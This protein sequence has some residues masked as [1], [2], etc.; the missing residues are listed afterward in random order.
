MIRTGNS[1][2]F[3]TS[4]SRLFTVLAVLLTIGGSLAATSAPAGAAPGNLADIDVADVD[5]QYVVAALTAGGTIQVEMVACGSTCTKS[6]WSSLGGGFKSVNVEYLAQGRPVVIARRANG[7][8]WY[9][10]GSCSATNCTWINWKDLGG[11]VIDLATSGYAGNCV[12]LAGQSSTKR[13]YQA[14]VCTSTAQGW[15]YAGGPLDQIAAHSDLIFGTS[16]SHQMWWFKNGTWKWAGG[17]VTQPAAKFGDTE[18][19]GIAQSSRRLWCVNTS[20]N[21]WTNHGGY[22]RKLDD[23]HTIGIGLAWDA[24]VLDGEENPGNYGEE[25]IA[26]SFGGKVNEVAWTESKDFMV[27]IGSDYRPWYQGTLGTGHGTWRAL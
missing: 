3:R 10:R 13:V 6:G 24:W 1:H 14:R 22:W 4:R 19:C 23:D 18:L 26:T 2:P 20:T 5:G 27:G 16:S 7:A 11:S 12:L 21:K 17:N 15:I 25:N 8:T 9:K